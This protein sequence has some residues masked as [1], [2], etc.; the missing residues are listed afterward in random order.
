MERLDE[1]RMARRVLMAE[2]SG[3]RVRERPR[4]GWIDGV[5]VAL[6]NRGMTMEA[7]RKDRKEWRPL[8]HT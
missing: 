8:V 2:V 4:L 6:G 7:A 3:G 1:F 5:K